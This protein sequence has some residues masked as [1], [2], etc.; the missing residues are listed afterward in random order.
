MA[1]NNSNGLSILKQDEK[2]AEVA[3]FESLDKKRIL[4]EH[5]KTQLQNLDLTLLHKLMTSVMVWCTQLLNPSI[6]R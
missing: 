6:T 3:S 1:N 4:N 5:K 2:T